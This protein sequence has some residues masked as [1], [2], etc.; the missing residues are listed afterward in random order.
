MEGLSVMNE[1]MIAL[2]PFDNFQVG[3]LC[4]DP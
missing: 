3:M 4:V 2:H 1:A